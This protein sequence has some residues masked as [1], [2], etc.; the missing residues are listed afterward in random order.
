MYNE[1]PNGEIKMARKFVKRLLADGLILSVY[2]G[3]EWAVKKSNDFSAIWDALGNTDSDTIVARENTEAATLVGKFYLVWGND[4]A[5]S[6]LVADHS[7]NGY[8]NA[9]WKDTFG[10]M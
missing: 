5:G 1:R 3:E 7:D 10:N 4:P 9:I 8:C 6:E 2:D